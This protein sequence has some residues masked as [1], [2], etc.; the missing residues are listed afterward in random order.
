MLLPSVTS[1]QNHTDITTAVNHALRLIERGTVA[2][3]AVFAD[4]LLDN[5]KIGHIASDG[6][7]HTRW[8]FYPVDRVRR[9]LRTEVADPRRFAATQVLPKWCDRARL[10][11]IWT[12]R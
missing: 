1:V 8:T 3:S 12:M 7:T 4:V 6:Y 10:G 11:D 5:A 9:R 2:W